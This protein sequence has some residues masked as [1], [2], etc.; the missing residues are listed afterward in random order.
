MRRVSPKCEAVSDEL[1]RQQMQARFIAAARQH[2]REKR[3]QE[4][5]G[6][7]GHRYLKLHQRET[8]SRVPVFGDFI[9]FDAGPCSFMDLIGAATALVHPSA[10]VPRDES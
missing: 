6:T 2:V 7:P 3:N 10:D 5:T 9:E 4:D 8:V 1:T